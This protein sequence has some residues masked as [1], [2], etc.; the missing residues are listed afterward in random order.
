MIGTDQRHRGETAEKR[1][2]TAKIIRKG[3]GG[4]GVMAKSQGGN[5]HNQG[6]RGLFLYTRYRRR[7]EGFGMAKNQGG[8]VGIIREEAR[9]LFLY[10]R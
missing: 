6:G 10:K 8:G 1:F 7:G 3:G 9:G 5:G 4:F 2:A